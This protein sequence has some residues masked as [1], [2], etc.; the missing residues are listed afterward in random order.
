M[1]LFIRRYD[2]LKDKEN[3]E[4]KL[5]KL[6]GKHN[7]E[8]AIRLAW[9]DR[10]RKIEAIVQDDSLP[11]ITPEQAATLLA[12]VYAE[13]KNLMERKEKGKSLKDLFRT[14]KAHLIQIGS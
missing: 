3:R 2:N 9:E 13:Y 11:S 10:K 14:A 7:F 5:L 8:A 1:L 4:K 6:Q 12:A